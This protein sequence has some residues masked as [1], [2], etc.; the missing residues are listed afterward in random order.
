MRLKDFLMID[1]LLENEVK[2]GINTER[3][4]LM[5]LSVR[6]TVFR[7]Q[8]AQT[9]NFGSTYSFGRKPHLF[10]KLF[11]A[12]RYSLDIIRFIT[13]RKSSRSLILIT[14]SNTSISDNSKDGY[15]DFCS[16]QEIDTISISTGIQKL[17]ADYS[18][19]T[20]TFVANIIASVLSLINIT[21]TKKTL[22]AMLHSFQNTGDL[23]PTTV[24]TTFLLRK[25]Y[26]NLVFTR[27]FRLALITH[28]KTFQDVYIE[29]GHYQEQVGLNKYFADHGVTVK[30]HQHG[31]VHYCHD[32]YNFPSALY[33][34]YSPYLPTQFLVFDDF[35]SGL[36]RIPGNCTVIGWYQH[37]EH[38]VNVEKV[39]D[40]NPLCTFIGTGLDTAQTISLF[41]Q[42]RSVY[43]NVTVKFRPHPMEVIAASQLLTDDEIDN[44]SLVETL[45]ESKYIIGWFSTVLFEAQRYGCK[46]FAIENDYLTVSGLDKFILVGKLNDHD[47]L[48][49]YF[50]EQTPEK[51]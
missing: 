4:I 48:C 43:K 1:K 47:K 27:L 19:Y 46:V 5:W 16:A 34:K 24:P 8:E 31:M 33:D 17:N 49:H 6:N 37:H 10:L 29:E 45:T 40:A 14:G 23:H 22:L 18:F 15:L 3:E 12:L 42:I 2:L 51:N 32:A 44:L 20:I 21:A 25:Y 30:E 13:S 41:R 26:K 36:I 50:G 39:P 28:N 38:T 9:Y 7:D 35:W 11:S